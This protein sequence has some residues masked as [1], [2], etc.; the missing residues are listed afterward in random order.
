MFHRQDIHAVLLKTAL[1]EE[2]EGPP[3]K[4]FVDHKIETVEAE[5]GKV[6]FSNGVEI[7]A[8]LVVG[9]DGI[10]VRPP[11][12]LADGRLTVFYQ[13]VTREQ[14]GIRAR[15]SPAPIA[16]YRCNIDRSRV[17][18]LGLNMQYFDNEGIEFW[19]GYPEG[20]RSP[21]YKIVL[22]PC[23]GGDTLSFYVFMPVSNLILSG[24]YSMR[25]SSAGRQKSTT[26]RGVLV[27][28]GSCRGAY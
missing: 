24:G 18:E 25:D 23:R 27:Q 5:E 14:I 10:R 1:S 4:L 8:D 6:T 17:Q 7:N 13:S 28:G 22:S 20:D 11:D 12:L 15:I 9:A 16:A 19:G 26:I 3:A 21:Y 2:G